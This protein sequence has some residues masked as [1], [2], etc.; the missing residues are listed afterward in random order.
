MAGL[1]DVGVVIVSHQSAATLDATLSALPFAELAAVVL[2]DN[3]SSD[4]SPGIGR[5][6]GAVVVEQPNL[7][8][9]AGN[10]RGNAELTCELVLFLNPDARLERAALVT[11]V[12]YLNA[13][14][15][16]AVVGPLV[17]SGGQPS[18]SA[19]RLTSLAGELRP[20]LP[21]PLSRVGPRR[22]YPP[23]YATSGPVGYVEGA[24]FLVRRSVLAAVGGFDEGYFL[25]AEELEL[26]QRLRRLGQEVHLCAEAAVEHVMGASTAGTTLGGEPHKVTSMVRYYRRWHGERAARTWVRAARASWALRVRTGAMP[27]E[28]ARALGAAARRAL[29]HPPPPPAAP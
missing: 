13:H 18:Y 2:V 15:R 21:D 26:G 17:R 16:C 24:C 5:R 19:G 8:F 23:A 9:G 25:Y 11:L 7:G 14:P 20:L 10:N 1:G 27:A 22:R 28:H 29:S 4:G 6:A 12:E 3:A